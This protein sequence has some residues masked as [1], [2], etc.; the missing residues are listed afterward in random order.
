MK[1]LL[2]LLI[3]AVSFGT[4]HADNVR[5]VPFT[6]ASG[7]ETVSISSFTF[8]KIPTTQVD[9][10][11]GFYVGVPSTNTGDI[12]GVAGNCTSTSVATT[13]RPIQMIKGTS[14]YFFKYNQGMCLWL[15]TTH[16]SAENVH[17]EQVIQ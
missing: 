10:R 9:G 16:T 1:K 2:V 13:V 5:E 7:S 4:V 11:W 15:I 6:S 12:V 8:T 14:S 3:L 17:V